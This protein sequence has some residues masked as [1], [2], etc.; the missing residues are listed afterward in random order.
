M[1][2]SSTKAELILARFPGPVTLHSSRKK[3]LSLFLC[4]CLIGAGGLV[5]VQYKI[6]EGWFLFIFF[7]AL[8]I[9]SMG[10]LWP[11]ASALTLGSLGF[12]VTKFFRPHRARWQDVSRFEAIELYTGRP[13]KLVVSEKMVVYD[14]VSA[15]SGILATVNKTLADHNAYL[16]DT[17]GLKGEELAWLMTQWRERAT[18]RLQT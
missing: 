8:S 16:P 7:G 12:D 6:S 14:D 11:G 1:Q 17:Y 10:M 15:T 2:S 13:T 4:C 9:L 5:M 18:G 3:W